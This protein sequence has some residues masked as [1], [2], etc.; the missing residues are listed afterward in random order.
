MHEIDVKL[1][2][3]EVPFLLHDAT[4]ERT[5]SGRGFSSERTWEELRE[6]DA[7]LWHSE[8]F[9]GEKLP[10]FEQVARALQEKGTLINVEIK[11]S[12]AS[13]S[14]PGKRL[15]RPPRPLWSGAPRAAASLVVLVRGADG[16]KRAAPHLAAGFLTRDIV[17]ADWR[18]LDELDATAVHT[19]YRTFQ[20]E[21]L[22]RATRAACACCST[23]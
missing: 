4:L 18:R 19:D 21:N 1:S 20:M 3:D 7:G 10:S 2:R 17:T 16:G 12:P 14:S 8:G 23:P 13:R 6:Y 22:A 5:T 15:P 9:R 11:P